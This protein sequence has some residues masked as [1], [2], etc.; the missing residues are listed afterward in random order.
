MSWIDYTIFALYMASI[1]GIGIYFF[2]KNKTHED[3]YVGGRDISSM[4]IE[5]PRVVD[6]AR[7]FP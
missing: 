3:Y 6:C 5:I 4:S 2:K 1:V 7:R